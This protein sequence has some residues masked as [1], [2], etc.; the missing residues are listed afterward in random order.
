MNGGVAGVTQPW[1]QVLWPPADPTGGGVMTAVRMKAIPAIGRGLALIEG[2]GMQMPMDAM[3]G[4]VVLPRPRLL[5][6]PDPRPGRDRAWFVG[7]QL[8]DYLVHGNALHYVTAYT[9][10]NWPA[11]VMHLPACEMQ[12]VVDP[13]GSEYYYWRGRELDMSRVVHVRRGA[14]PLNPERGWGVLEQYM[15]TL[16][17]IDK[18]GRYEESVMDSAAVPSAA[19]ETTNAKPS[20]E[21]MDAAADRWAEKFA[22]P[23]RK[24]VFLPAGWTVK[25][26]SWSPA[27]S[28]LVEARQLSLVDAANILNLDS[29]WVG[30][31]VASGLTYRSP[32]PM[33]LN[34]L[35]QTFAP[36]L[37]SFELVWS[38]AWLPQDRML[39]FERE[40]ILA[41]DKQTTVSWV[42]RAVASR[43]ITQSEGRVA[44]GYSADLPAELHVTEHDTRSLSAA[45]V[46]QKVYLAVAN[47]V[48][49]VEE[50]RQMIQDAGADLSDTPP[51]PRPAPP[52]ADGLPDA[53]QDETLTGKETE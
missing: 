38:Q 35:R 20:Q 47:G 36:I 27:D 5:A 15:R 4:D 2:M 8:D 18:Q 10:S 33:W 51:A 1:N 9:P 19:V 43:L 46:S 23:Q 14:D 40:A 30:G 11:A 52:V 50:A 12:L 3:R 29:F 16:A 28:Q 44:L 48:L 17:R 31:S 32:G 34:L 22:G 49:T 21:E 13:H 24:P 26:L 41:E 53:D 45:E 37:T 7:Q 6:Q 42:G 39:R 25:P